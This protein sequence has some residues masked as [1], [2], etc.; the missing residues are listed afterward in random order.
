MRRYQATINGHNKIDMFTKHERMGF[1]NGE[2]NRGSIN[3]AKW[4]IRFIGTRQQLEGNHR[5][6]QKKVEKWKQKLLV[7]F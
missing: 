3:K 5:L 6:E 7:R 2:E 4:K 1:T